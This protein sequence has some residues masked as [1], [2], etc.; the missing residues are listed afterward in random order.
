M[1]RKLLWSLV[2]IGV[3]AVLSVSS[4]TTAPKGAPWMSLEMPVNPFDAS[5]RGAAFLVHAYLHERPVGFPAVGSA[6]G[7]VDGKRQTIALEFQETSRPGVYAVHPQWPSKGNWILTLGLNAN[8]EMPFLLVELG[9]NGGVGDATAYDTKIK[10]LAIRSVQ[11][12]QGRLSAAQI[13]A[14]LRAMSE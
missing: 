14:T 4:A 2:P 12:I 11:L 9:P 3:A 6:E 8:R 7:L 1:S 10:T 13:E 5:T